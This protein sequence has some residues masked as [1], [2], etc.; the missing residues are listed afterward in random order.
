MNH[1]SAI[2][3]KTTLLLGFFDILGFSSLVITCTFQMSFSQNAIAATCLRL[4]YLLFIYLLSYLSILYLGF[5]AL[6]RIL[7]LHRA[8]RLFIKGG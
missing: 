7:H 2:F 3:L 6:S 4:F 5:T 8:D 1:N